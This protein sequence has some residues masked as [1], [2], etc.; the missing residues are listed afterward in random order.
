MNEQKLLATL[1]Q[2]NRWWNNF[3]VPKTLLK[4]EHKRRDFFTMRN[5]LDTNEIKSIIGPRQVGKT[6]LMGQ[7]IEF[8]IKDANI[9]PKNILYIPIDNTMLLTASDNILED[10]LKVYSQ[11]ILGSDLGNLKENIYVYLDEIQ[12]LDRWP[13]QLKSWYDMYA[14]IRFIITGSSSTKIKQDTSESLVGRI[15]RRTL[16]PFKFIEF[17]R[18][19]NIGNGENINYISLGLRD[20]LKNCVDSGDYR[21]IY[22][23]LMESSGILSNVKAEILSEVN[24]YL[25]KGG[26]PTVIPF[27]EEY[28][29]A[30]EKLF[31]DLELTVYKDIKKIYNIDNP[32]KI[33][34]ILTALADSS[35]EIVSISELGREIGIEWRT[36]ENYLYYLE[37]AYLITKS[38]CYSTNVRRRD[39]KGKKIYIADV[40]HRNAL[41][42]QM[43]KALLSSSTDLGKIVQTVAFQHAIRL[44]FNFSN[45]TDFHVYYWRNHDTEVDIVI[46][47]EN[48]LPIEVKITDNIGGSDRRG[49]KKFLDKYK[50]SNFGIILTKDR[51]DF[52]ENILYM[53][54]WQFLI[55]C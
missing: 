16:M 32:D 54:L 29:R 46:D 26:Y 37:S 48:L 33:M 9:N 27:A 20:T 30:Y 47:R 11:Y 19:R 22:Q 53:P 55:M 31:N 4:S 49:L 25:I 51:I 18:Y 14:K 12:N 35:G 45:H 3:E 36:A 8:Q 38:K 34:A 52:K 15:K 41:L 5:Q 21:P 40:G 24:S 10:C 44:K 42:S 23:R 2:L 1:V 17:I 50:N 39:R 7:L 43:N 6:T 13:E 28:D